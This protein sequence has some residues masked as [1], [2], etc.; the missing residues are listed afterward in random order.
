MA[1]K[2][3]YFDAA[4]GESDGNG[5]DLQQLGN[6][7]AVVYGNE[8]QV[9]LALFGGNVEQNTP[10]LVTKEQT[11]DWWANNLFHPNDKERQFNSNTERTLNTTALNSSGRIKI[12][13]AV[14]DDLAFLIGLGATFTVNVTIPSVNT[15]TI[16]I[17]VIYSE[18]ARRL[19]I[20][21]FGK[22]F[23]DGDFSILDFNEDFY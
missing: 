19:T 16:E 10:A 23:T 3:K 21:T 22:R 15:V 7:L 17:R 12:E 8:N 13:S 20:I 4:I 18:T 1:T 14:K 6:D 11:F 2:R 5:G 9:Y